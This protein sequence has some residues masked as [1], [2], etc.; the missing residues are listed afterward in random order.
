MDETG[1]FPA[2]TWEAVNLQAA[3]R[4]FVFLPVCWACVCAYAVG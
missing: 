4:S 2:T 1:S 3:G